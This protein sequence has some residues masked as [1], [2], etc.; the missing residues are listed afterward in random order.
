MLVHYRAKYTVNYPAS[1]MLLASL[2]PCPCGYYNHPSRACDCPPGAVQK[3]LN[4]V[5]GPLLDR[6]DIHSEVA[7]VAFS[8]LAGTPS[9]EKSESIR[10]RVIRVRE[11]QR[12]RFEEREGIYCNAQIP[13]Q[14]MRAICQVDPRGQ[15]LLKAAMERL[16]LSARAYDRI[17][18]VARTIA[19]LAGSGH[20]KPEHIAEAIHLRTLARKNL[21]Q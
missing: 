20:T 7:P 15:A 5:S 17:L 13:A 14:D 10:E 19:D 6:I 2:N 9:S 1:F 8:D 18:K 4:R 16:H 12:K 3:Y 11:L 21:G